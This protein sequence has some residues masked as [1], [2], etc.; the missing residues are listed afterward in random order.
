MIIKDEKFKNLWHGSPCLIIGSGRTGD[1]LPFCPELNDFPGKI[2][3]C[4]TAFEVGYRTDMIIWTDQKLIKRIRAAADCLKV[5]IT[6]HFNGVDYKDNG[7]HWI[8]A[9]GSNGRFS[10]SFDAGLYPADLTGYTA[11]N[12][13]YIM[14]CNPIFLFGFF[15][16]QHQY[17]AKHKRFKLAADQAAQDGREVY[18]CDADSI[19][20]REGIFEYRSCFETK[21]GPEPVLASEQPPALKSKLKKGG[22][23]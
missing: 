14:G 15:S 6:G 21:P 19:L 12:T 1:Y 16:E 13:A 22:K 8:K 20:C 2:V 23:K 17:F 4:N 11:L 7:I 5:S 3:G 18:V 9:D 10:D